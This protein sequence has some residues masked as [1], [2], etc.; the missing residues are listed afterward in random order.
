MFSFCCGATFE[1]SLD[2]RDEIDYGP[3]S[4]TVSFGGAGDLAAEDGLKGWHLNDAFTLSNLNFTIR[5]LDGEKFE[6]LFG[7]STGSS[8][9]VARLTF[10]EPRMN[11]GAL[12]MFVGEGSRRRSAR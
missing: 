6:A 10:A 7:R 9:R 5:F 1:L 11:R 12:V 2:S 4:G 3:L 8:A